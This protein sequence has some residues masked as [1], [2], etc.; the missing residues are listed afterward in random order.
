[1]TICTQGRKLLFGE[2]VGSEMVLNEYGRVVG[3]CWEWLTR[4]YPY[5]QLDKWVVMPNHIHGII[6]LGGS[7]T[8]PTDKQKSLSSIV[9]AFKTVSTSSI[10]R[11]RRSPGV[12]IWQR[13]YYEH[14]IREEEDLDHVRQYLIYNP[15]RWAEDEENPFRR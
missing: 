15:G 7:R 3:E 1:V 9:G 6:V 11:L 14:I 12:P 2:I 5:V 4:Q 8:A 10:N 13:N